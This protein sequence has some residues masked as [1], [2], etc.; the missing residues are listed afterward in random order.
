[1]KLKIVILIISVVI[2]IST[3]SVFIFLQGRGPKGPRAII[4][5]N[6]ALDRTSL[7]GDNITFV[8][9]T[10]EIL[11]D[12][13]V[14][15]DYVGANNV[16][17][18]VYRNLVQYNLVILRVHSGVLK[19]DDKKVVCFFTSEELS[20]Q[21]YNKYREWFNERY[22]A[23]ATLEVDGS[24]SFIGL[25][26]DFIHKCL[27]GEFHN[28]IIIAMGCNSSINDSM[29]KAF[30]DK[31]ARVYIGWNYDVTVDYT[32]SETLKLLRRFF[33][34]NKKVGEAIRGLRDLKTGATLKYYPN[35]D[36]TANLRP[37]TLI[38]QLLE[39]KSS[40]IP[41]I[42]NIILFKALL[43]NLLTLNESNLSYRRLFR[44]F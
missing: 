25:K 31:K 8:R 10:R 28:S 3:V 22:L 5:D 7:S 18:E 12:I 38:S 44:K 43:A 42:A 27:N 39:K 2:C 15:V 34:E 35:D 30:I 26:P 4:V 32:D 11:G 1:M 40:F 23:N 16:T 17:L 37:L 24:K 36:E 29:A 19:E 13:G 6:L 21:S 9:E 20:G 14:E 41:D 33:E